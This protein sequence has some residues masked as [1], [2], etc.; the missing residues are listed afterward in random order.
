MINSGFY[1]NWMDKTHGL[2]IIDMQYRAAMHGGQ[3]MLALFP[4]SIP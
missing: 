4:V 1:L 3:D 2:F